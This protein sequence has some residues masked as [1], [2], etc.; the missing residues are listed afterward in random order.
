MKRARIAELKNRLSHYLQFVRR[1]QSVLVYDRD[2]PIARIEP[3]RDAAQADPDNWTEELQR[4]GVLKPPVSGLPRDWL[5]RRPS[6]SSDILGALLDERE[7][8]R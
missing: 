6:T 1:G 2:T 3:V 8:G 7:G 4:A 5:K